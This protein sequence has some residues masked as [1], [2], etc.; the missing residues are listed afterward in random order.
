MRA[1]IDTDTDNGQ[2]V[3]KPRPKHRALKAAAGGANMATATKA[4]ERRRLQ[5]D[6]EKLQQKWSPP[7]P[8]ASFTSATIPDYRTLLESRRR[9]DLHTAPSAPMQTIRPAPAAPARRDLPTPEME[10]RE[11]KAQAIAEQRKKRVAP[12]YNKGGY[13][14]IS[15]DT[16][17]TTMGRKV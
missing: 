14:Y 10:E 11:R 2:V 12:A 5:A 6:W 8:M 16:D 9:G 15:D 7:K 4:A 13:Q 17:L 3:M 1:V